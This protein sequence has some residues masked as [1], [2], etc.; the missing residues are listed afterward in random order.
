MAVEGN[1]SGSSMT[2]RQCDERVVLQAA[3]TYVLMLRE[4]QWEQPSGFQEARAPRGRLDQN[5]R[6]DEALNGAP[7]SPAAPAQ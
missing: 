7:A 5:E 3:E 4:Y 2:R 6:L 1:D